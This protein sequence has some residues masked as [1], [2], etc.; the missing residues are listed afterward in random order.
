MAAE[1]FY[2]MAMQIFNM[3]LPLFAAFG[4]LVLIL[5]IV[6]KSPTNAGNNLALKLVMTG[7][8]TVAPNKQIML[9]RRENGTYAIKKADYDTQNGGYWIK[10]GKNKQ[11][12]E[13]NG[14]IPGTLGGIKLLPAYEGLGALSDFASA[15]VAYRAKR[16]YVDSDKDELVDENNENVELE[17]TQVAVPTR[18]I[19]DLRDIRYLAPYNVSPESFFR[20]EENAK[21]S[22][23]RFNMQNPTSVAML[24][25]TAVVITMIM[26]WFLLSQGGGGGGGISMP[27]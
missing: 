20:V 27:I 23:S 22:M 16:K 18:R 2:I 13:S 4:F 15:E 12:F 10:N 19:I 14:D 25:I 9:L 7:L 8:N 6:L 24:V 5:F 17:E 1:Q 26:T 3:I 11:F 21:I